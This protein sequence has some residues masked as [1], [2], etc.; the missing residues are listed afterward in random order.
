ML[1]AAI[2]VPV[3]ALG[4]CFPV[5]EGENIAD[6]YG[7]FAGFCGFLQDCGNDRGQD[8]QN[9]T[10]RREEPPQTGDGTPPPQTGG[11]TEPPPE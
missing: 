9:S 8:R 5:Q 4:G 6:E 1:R 7:D 3:I 2:L 10:A 11:A